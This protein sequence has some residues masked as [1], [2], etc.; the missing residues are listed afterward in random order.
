MQLEKKR[1][2]GKLLANASLALLC[3][4]SNVALADD[5][6][7]KEPKESDKGFLSRNIESITS[8]A[9]WTGELGILG[10]SESNG[11]VQAVEPAIKLNAEFDGERVWSTKLVIDTLTGSSPNGALNSDQ[12][13]TFTSPSGTASYVTNANEQP[14]YDQFKDTRI[15]L[16]TS[17]TQPISR[18]LKFSAG[19]NGSNEFDYLSLGLNTSLTKESED[20]NSSWTMGFSFTSD[21]VK[22]VGGVPTPLATMVSPGSG[23]ARSGTSENK[24]T[25]DLLLGYTQVINREWIM[26]GNLSVG[27]SDGYMN[28]PY[29]FVTIYDDNVGGTLG[30]PTSYIHENRPDNRLKKSL[31]IASKNHFNL[32]VL[33]LGYR[34]LNDDWGLSSHTIDAAFNI[35]VSKNWRVEP[36]F[37]YYVQ[38]AVDFYKLALGNSQSTPGTVTADYRLGD[39]TA[40]TPGIKVTKKLEKGRELSFI[41]RYYMQTSDIDSFTPVGSQVGQDLIP[42]TDA[43][44]IQ[45]HYS[46]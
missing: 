17:W 36:S 21:S 42:D 40:M 12:P 37:R 11:R 15:N 44:V 18:L 35:N 16:A 13:Q 33:S 43:I 6:A 28:D 20:K 45:S 46:F 34:F 4:T 7:V 10:Y 27:Y 8:W 22:P 26:Q 30:D 25:Y 24:T 32:G 19:F 31:Y 23:P 1:K 14:L 38:N 41:L 39:L 9:K 2:V 29:K 3:S 5:T